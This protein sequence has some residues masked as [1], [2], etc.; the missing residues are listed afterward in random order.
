MP[1]ISKDWKFFATLLATLAG[2]VVP[3][4]LWQSDHASRSLSVRLVSA[5]AL[6]PEKNP[7]VED[8]QITLDGVKIESPYLST[9]EL[10]NDGSKSISANEFESPLE[11]RV[12][13]N[14]QV[15]RARIEH[16]QP[17]GI[18][19]TLVSDKN[20]IKLQPL[21]LNPSDTLTLAIITSGGQPIFVPQ[22]RI[23]GV[24]KVLY[25]DTTT[26]K[27]GW[28]QAAFFLS[29]A[30]FSTVLYF[31]ASAY[32]IRPGTITLSRRLVF[33]TMI[34]FGFA[35]AHFMARG[36][37]AIEIE[38]SIFNVSA[39]AAVALMITLPFILRHLSKPQ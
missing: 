27:N 24:S 23:A 30:T 34:V 37:H 33:S 31:L 14:S 26:K 4:L 22:A 36:F 21:L 1:N 13:E 15:V 19:G 38:K 16:S 11:I 10:T 28:K 12:A 39:F 7:S 9:L 8:L 2:I 6:Q 32:L 25:E 5:V 17:N 35:S 18:P 3:I 29:L 20:I